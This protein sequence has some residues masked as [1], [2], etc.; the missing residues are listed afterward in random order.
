MSGVGVGHDYVR[1]VARRQRRGAARRGIDQP[2]PAGCAATPRVAPAR[3]GAVARDGGDGGCGWRRDGGRDARVPAPRQALAR[4]GRVRHGRLVPRRERSLHAGIR[5]PGRP[6]VARLFRAVARRAGPSASTGVVHTQA[7]ARH[8]VRGSSA[9]RR[10]G[11]GVSGR[12][13]RAA[14]AG[15]RGAQRSY[16]AGA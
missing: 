2:R 13:R 12:L 9:A 14:A 10:H 3:R 4:P 7:P 6:A 1:V 15:G 16:R 11:P 8:A 5:R